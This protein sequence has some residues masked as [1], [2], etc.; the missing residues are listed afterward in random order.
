MYEPWHFRYLGKELA[1][2]LYDR[3][4]TYQEYLAELD[5]IDLVI[6]EE[7]KE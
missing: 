2:L 7:M 4:L 1:Q 5:I 3:Q 6:H